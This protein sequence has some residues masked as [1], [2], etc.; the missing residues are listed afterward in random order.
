MLTHLLGPGVHMEVIPAWVSPPWKARP[1]GNG[2]L[3]MKMEDAIAKYNSDKDKHALIFADGLERNDKAGIGMIATLRRIPIKSHSQRVAEGNG[4][5]IDTIELGAI[6]EAVKWARYIAD[7]IPATAAVDMGVVVYS[8]SQKAIYNIN[9]QYAAKGAEIVKEIC[10]LVHV[11]AASRR[12]ISIRWIPKASK[13]PE[14]M[15]A[16]RLA[17]LSTSGN[18]EVQL[19]TWSQAGSRKGH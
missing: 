10:N 17:R 2:G 4:M 1:T 13:I 19:T 8:D 3:V 11:P 7:N 16:D 15:E 9:S 12:E 5:A 6:L 18:Q 14:H